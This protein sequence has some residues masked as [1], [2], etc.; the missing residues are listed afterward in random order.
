MMIIGAFGQTFTRHRWR[1]KFIDNSSVNL[2]YCVAEIVKRSLRWRLPVVDS[3]TTRHTHVL[4]I[5]FELSLARRRQCPPTF[6]ND[7]PL[8]LIRAGL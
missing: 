5:H 1:F 8:E 6:L 4:L 3:G 7:L 2:L